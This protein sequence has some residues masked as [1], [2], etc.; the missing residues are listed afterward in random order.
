[1]EHSIFTNAKIY[2]VD[3]RFSIQEAVVVKDGKIAFTGKHADAISRFRG[4]IIDCGGKFLYPGFHDPH[5]HFIDLGRAYFS[6]WLYETES[7]EAMLDKVKAFA[8]KT[9]HSWIIGRG[10]D[11]NLWPGKKIPSLH[12]LDELFP[13]KPVLLIRVDSH[14]A[15]VNSKTIE[16]GKLKGSAYATNGMMEM[17]DGEPTGLLM[18]KA[19]YSLLPYAKEQG[20]LLEK[21]ILKSQEQCL[22]LG[23]TSL[24]DAWVQQDDFHWF[25]SLIEKDKLKLRLYC[26]ALPSKEN[27]EYFVSNGSY[28]S[29]K[30]ICRSFK[31]FADGALGSRGAALL[32]PYSDM[33]FT[34]GLLLE[35][36]D[37]W[38]EEAEWCMEKGFQMITHCI[39]DA[40]NRRVLDVYASK[41][42]EKNDKRWRIEHAQVVHPDDMHKFA[43]YRIIPCVQSTHG[44]SDQ[45]WAIDRLGADRIMHAYRLKDFIDLLGVLPNGSDFPIEY[46]NPLY[47]FYAS[48]S[49]QNLDGYP[50]GGFQ[51]SQKLSREEAL[52][53]MTIYAAYAQFEE[54]VKGSIAYGRYADFTLLDTDLMN[55][56][57]SD[58]PKAKVL[59]TIIG[60]EVVYSV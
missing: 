2:T 4:K 20:T 30:L 51:P 49:R 41:L 12:I 43:D 25:H 59:K 50:E 55:C 18:D 33:P 9:E 58:I 45:K 36:D 52:K 13:D 21:I 53:G 19:F 5:C 29:E 34:K 35:S 57:V 47:G 28:L 56:E 32:E 17:M 40:A 15:L 26:M 60:G 39:G 48:I 16:I 8:E 6:A 46:P 37:Y 14:A 10:W 7:F 22:S 24:G 27:K 54:G 3:D 11:Q 31:Y 44:T 42:K 38:H 23:L 1:M